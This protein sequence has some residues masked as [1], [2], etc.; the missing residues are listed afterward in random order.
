M[1]NLNLTHILAY[2]HC[3]DLLGNLVNMSI[4]H[5]Y[6]KQY[7]QYLVHM[8]LVCMDLKMVYLE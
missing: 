3:V 5:G 6:L 4:L 7:N 1:D 2:I 8:D